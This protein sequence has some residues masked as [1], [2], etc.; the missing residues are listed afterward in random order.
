[1]LPAIAGGG[2]SLPGN[3]QNIG[4]LPGQRIGVIDAI[5][6]TI[7]ARGWDVKP[8]KNKN[9]TYPIKSCFYWQTESFPRGVWRKPARI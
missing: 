6:R 4:Y 5:N 7:V 3:C 1:M 8:C 2:T 9:A